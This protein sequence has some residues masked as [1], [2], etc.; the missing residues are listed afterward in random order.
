MKI[1]LDTSSLI[2]LYHTENGTDYI[3]K[4][5]EDYSIKEI[6]LSDIAK[7]E[8]NSAIW[9]KVRTK[10]L[11]ENEAND[12]IDSFKADYNNYTFVD[13]NTDLVL[14]AR[15]L[16][17]KYG[18]N[19]LRTLD[20]IQLASILKVKTELSFVMTADDLLRSLTE[21]EGLKAKKINYQ[22]LG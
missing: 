9:K 2:K 7:V 1:F 12:I 3:D 18:L 20:S 5:F 15:D 10:D 19:G 8:F 13:L 16:V 4:L 6:F 17:A 11:T 21:L 14:F 22:K